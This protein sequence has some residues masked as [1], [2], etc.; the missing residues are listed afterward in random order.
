MLSGISPLP[1][2]GTRIAIARDDAFLFAYPAVLEGWRRAGA[3]LA[4]FSPL[5]DEMPDPASDAVY[6]P[7]GYP[8]LYA[9]RLA[10]AGH[11]LAALRRGAADGT[12]IYGECGGYMALGES[13]V[14]GDGRAHRMAGLLPLR[15]SFAKPRLPLGYRAVTLFGAGPLGP[16]GA[17]FR[18]HEF[19]Y[20]TTI[21]AG[22][23]GAAAPLFAL[24]DSEGQD[25][26]ASGLRQGSV[27]GSFIH[28]IDRAED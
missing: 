8:E 19:H 2:L 11:F 12:A 28:L 15:T 17:R 23:A 5:A 7:G 27:M 20:A 1:P 22:T 25:L 26:G 4:F 14:D 16:A 10:A 9:G 3:E 13:L 21:A 24:A 6:L 18:G